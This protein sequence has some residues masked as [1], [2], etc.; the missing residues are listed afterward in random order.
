MQLNNSTKTTNMSRNEP[1]SK[2]TSS[3]QEFEEKSNAV[4]IGLRYPHLREFSA[5]EPVQI[6]WV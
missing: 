5:Q 2:Q 1:F 3:T 6:G 4:G